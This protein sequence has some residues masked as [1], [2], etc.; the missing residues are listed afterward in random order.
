MSSTNLTDGGIVVF[1][2]ISEKDNKLEKSQKAG[3]ATEIREN[4]KID[5]LDE[6]IQS[7]IVSVKVKPPVTIDEN[8]KRSD[9]STRQNMNNFKQ[10]RERMKKINNTM[11]KED[12]DR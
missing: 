3:D 5:R 6:I 1:S 10:K 8:G 12:K 11:K 9:G 4:G 7:E 2:F